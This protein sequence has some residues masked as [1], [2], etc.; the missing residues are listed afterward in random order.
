MASSIAA[1]RAALAAQ[2]QAKTNLKMF[3]EQPDQIN[4]PCGAV[5][6]GAPYVKY[7]ITLGEPTMNA[8]IGHQIPVPCEVNL[9]V[10]VYMARS[11]SL[12]RA[13]QAVDTYLGFFPNSSQVSIPMAILSDPTLG[14]VVEYAEPMQVQAYGDINIAGQDYF[15]GRITVAVSVTQD[16]S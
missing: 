5:L 11:P 7:G 1:V 13:Q 16:L 9:V 15:Q 6:P 2:I 10:A 8:P 4:P 14:G 3:T 12:Q